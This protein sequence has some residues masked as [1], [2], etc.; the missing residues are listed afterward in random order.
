[1]KYLISVLKELQEEEFTV[2]TS[3]GVLALQ[4]TQRNKTK[5]KILK[6][7]FQ[8]MKEELEEA[9]F[10]VY[11]TSYGPVIEVYNEKVETDVFR[12]EYDLWKKQGNVGRMTDFLGSKKEVLPSG[13]ITIQSDWIMKNLDVNAT[14]DEASYIMEQEQKVLR[15]KEKEAKKRKKI[16]RDAEIRAE[17]AR[18]REEAVAK[19]ERANS[20][21]E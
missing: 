21:K 17:K 13:R 10:S 20:A 6:A 14:I 8:D 4:Q 2:A 16:E 3:R 19:I 15:E 12:K 7:F 5:A 9:G 18:K 11:Q 1:M